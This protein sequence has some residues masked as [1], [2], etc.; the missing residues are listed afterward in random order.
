MPRNDKKSVLLR[1]I[2]LL[3]LLP[4]RGA[5]KTAS[6]LTRALNDAGFNITKRQ[7]ERDLNEL[8]EAFTLDRND[9]SIPHGWK[10][11]AGASVDLPGMT[12]TEALSLRLVEDTLKPLMPVSMLEGLETRFRQAEKQ[13]LAL[14]KENRKAKWASKVR[15]VTPAMP[16]MPPEID[17]AALSTV[18]EAL[19]SD[20]QIEVDYQAIRDEADKPMLLSPLALVNRGTVTYL[21]ATA[22]EYE[23]VR[24]YAMHRIRNA[25]RT[26]N[27]VKRPDGF[28]LDEYIQAGG[29]HFGYG[30]TIRLTALVSPVLARLLEETPM[31]E[32][33]Q[34]TAT[35]DKIKLTATVSDSWQLKWW[36]MSQGAG[37]EVTAPVA[38]RRKMGGL[39]A[40]AAALYTKGTDEV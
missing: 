7:V 5:S 30:K 31:S 38:L 18:Q 34:L 3:K 21:V 39:L 23:D 20:V 14:G 15:T 33:Q 6:E 26:N 17:S 29:M 16:L 13:L 40:D 35:D 32:D 11:V 28:D 8:M 27:T 2:E 22:F 24:L 4:T 9:S 25:T 36:L 12:I 37:I 19:L 10:W 1:Q